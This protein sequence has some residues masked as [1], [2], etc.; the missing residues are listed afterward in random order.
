[1]GKA[2]AGDV[3]YAMLVKIYGIAEGAEKRYS[4]AVCLGCESHTVT[5]SPDPKHINTSYVERH[6]LS[7]RM[8]VRRFT[9]LTNAFSKSLTHHV[10]A[11]ALGY[12]AYNFIKIHS[13]LRIT[14]AMAAGV[15]HHL[16]EARFSEP[17][18]SA[19]RVA[20]KTSRITNSVYQLRFSKAPQP[21]GTFS[22]SARCNITIRICE[23][24]AGAVQV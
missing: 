24:R 7:V 17:V 20:S 8:T 12:F 19:R 14:P 16:W 1:V 13:T 22:F 6:N 21:C 4:P 10:A 2:F 9:R 23:L 11:V 15:T 5:G 18:G 3:D